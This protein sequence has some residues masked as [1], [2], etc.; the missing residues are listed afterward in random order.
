MQVYYR[1]EI[2]TEV[3]QWDIGHVGI[4]ANKNNLEKG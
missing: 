4:L 1:R 2:A 3:I